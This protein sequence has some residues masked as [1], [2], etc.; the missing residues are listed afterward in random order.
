MPP[1]DGNAGVDPGGCGTS[2]GTGLEYFGP[3]ELGPCW[4]GQRRQDTNHIYFI[5]EV[6]NIHKQA[7]AEKDAL[8]FG[9][10]PRTERNRLVRHIM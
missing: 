5:A 7:L 4:R 2:F 8:G 6:G 10:S 9:T 1:D 3:P